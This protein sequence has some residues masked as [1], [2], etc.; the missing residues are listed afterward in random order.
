M[1]R[2][3]VASCALPSS[4]RERNSD[5]MIVR[6]VNEIEGGSMSEKSALMVVQEGGVGV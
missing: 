6:K 2:W 1:K 3:I 4:H 5:T